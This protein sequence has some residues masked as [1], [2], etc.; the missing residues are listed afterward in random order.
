[1]E[2]KVSESRNVV[3]LLKVEFPNQSLII[4]YST[5]LKCVCLGQADIL[6]IESTIILNS[7][8]ISR[9]LWLVIFLMDKN[10]FFYPK[11]GL[12]KSNYYFFFFF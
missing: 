8:N 1:M 7:F 2:N 11:H 3:P 4:Y 10:V 12:T 6:A 9:A 5:N